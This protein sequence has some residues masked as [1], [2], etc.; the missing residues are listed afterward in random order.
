MA[1]QDP[2]Q[3]VRRRR[4]ATQGVEIDYDVVAP[5][6]VGATGRSETVT[7]DAEQHVSQP[8]PHALQAHRQAQSCVSVHRSVA[9]H[10][11][12]TG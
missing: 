9:Y 7:G 12:A 2:S 1:R 3:T 11:P 8:Y 10:V 4:A 5:A 6:A